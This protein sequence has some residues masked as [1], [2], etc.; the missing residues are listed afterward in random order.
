MDL[1]QASP[2]IQHEMILF[3]LEHSAPI[4]YAESLEEE[5]GEE[6]HD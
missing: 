4:L 2:E 6:K 3:F 5:K 1:L